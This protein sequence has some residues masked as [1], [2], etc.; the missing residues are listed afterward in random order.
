VDK[1]K[2]P[3]AAFVRLKIFIGDLNQT[4]TVTRFLS[5][6]K[7]LNVEPD[8]PAVRIALADIAEH[9][10]IT[11]SRR[12]ILRFILAEPSRRSEEIQTLLKLEE[13][14][15]ARK[16]LNTAHNRLTTAKAEAERTERSFSSTLQLHL[17]I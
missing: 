8:I 7:K 17:Q 4:V 6:P 11:L 2:F 1:V 15:E 14:G 12:E 3:D 10:E 5:A 13:I 16:A 9:P